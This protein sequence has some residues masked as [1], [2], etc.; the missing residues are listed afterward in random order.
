MAS[1]EIG[2]LFDRNTMDQAFVN[3]LPPMSEHERVFA[4]TCNAA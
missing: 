4:L 1:T 3:E 2:D